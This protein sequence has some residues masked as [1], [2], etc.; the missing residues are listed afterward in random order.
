MVRPTLEYGRKVLYDRV[1]AAEFPIRGLN[2]NFEILADERI[3]F[4]VELCLKL[5]ARLHQVGPNF[6]V[7]ICG[8]NRD[9]I[10][11]SFDTLLRGIFRRVF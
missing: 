1:I 3:L 7:A 11:E 6:I 4:R 9:L 10:V 2:Q 5:L 8:Q